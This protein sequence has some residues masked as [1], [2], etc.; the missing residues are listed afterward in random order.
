[1]CLFREYLSMLIFM[2]ATGHWPIPSLVYYLLLHLCHQSWA[3]LV[4]KWGLSAWFGAWWW[5]VNSL[6]S[7]LTEIH[8]NLTRPS[9]TIWQHRLGPTF[10]Q[11]MA[12]CPMAPSS[13]LKQIWINFNEVC[14]HLAKQ[15]FTETVLD[16]TFYK[17]WKLHTVKSLIYSYTLLGNKIVH[18]SDVVGAPPAGAAPTT[19][20]FLT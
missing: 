15:N 8:S 13:H 2:L 10:V 6:Y 16:I 12:C 1:M 9:D 18:H 5:L 3:W 14:F 11:V 4:S 20:S 7:F 17:C 19:S